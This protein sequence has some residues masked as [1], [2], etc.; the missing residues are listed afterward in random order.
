MKKIFSIITLFALGILL[1]GCNGGGG[2]RA[3]TPELEGVRENL[4]ITVDEFKDFD[5]LEGIRATD[6]GDKNLT[7][8]IVTTFDEDWKE[9]T[10]DGKYTYSLSVTNEHGNYARAVVNLT[11]GNPTIELRHQRAFQ[12]YYLDSRAY[13]PTEGIEAF[14]NS[15]PS[16][17]LNVSEQ[18]KY[19]EEAWPE[20]VEKNKKYDVEVSVSN[21]DSVAKAI[22]SIDVHE[23]YEVAK[24]IPQ[25]TEITIW[26]ANGTDIV[27]LME[28]AIKEFNK[29][30][31]T[32]KVN[33]A[34]SKGNYDTI[35]E[36][37]NNAI[38]GG[39]P[40]NIVQGYP[41]HMAEYLSYNALE[42]L[43]PY[44]FDKT[45]GFE[46]G[47]G[48]V[49][50]FADIVGPYV[51]ENAGIGMD[52]EFYSMPFNKSTEVLIF[53]NDYVEK[54]WALDN[55]KFENGQYPETWEEMMTFADE[56]EKVK[57]DQLDFYNERR[58]V[59]WDKDRL[60]NYKEIFRPI[61]YDSVDNAAITALRQWGGAYT[62]KN[63]DGTGMIKFNEGEYALDV[64]KFFAQNNSRITIPQYYSGADYS[65]D[66]FK[67]GRVAA[68]VGSSGGARYNVPEMDKDGN[69]LFEYTVK[70]IPYYGK[71]GNR[72]VIQQGTNYGVVSMDATNEQKLAS[73]LLIKHFMSANM[74]VPFSQGTGYTPVR[75]S[76]ALDER[77]VGFFNGK[78]TIGKNA[79]KD[80]DGARLMN[81]QAI[82]AGIA[83]SPYQ[84]TDV[85]FVGSAAI[86]G[87]WGTALSQSILSRSYNEE[88]VKGYLNRAISNANRILG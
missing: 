19:K 86:R 14:D 24:E 66:M 39:T 60:A 37:M 34:E 54:V 63:S 82:Q 40:P 52:G 50:T 49:E 15:D 68:T 42:P 41:D 1:I 88:N 38:K 81:S 43:S 28:D 27:N 76:T 72:A 78:E 4:T 21:D 65:S 58:S 26:H 7:K 18:V 79:G 75:K 57:S 56:V 74:Q 73:W 2:K 9:E 67:A 17:P 29:Q 11:V 48:A 61:A 31:P 83:Q 53:N 5:P 46:H 77:M 6:R 13:L 47:E 8:D 36:D 3:S 45:F 10:K 59:E 44:M 80:L 22:L 35:R 70:P 16:N 32:I 84:F 55:A 20:A 30:Y 62:A 64:L 12:N 33:L 71:T 69:P 25:G 87:Y 23:E 51:V 85:A